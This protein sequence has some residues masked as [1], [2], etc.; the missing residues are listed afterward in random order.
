[1]R[2]LR[3]CARSPCADVQWDL[4]TLIRVV[5]FCCFPSDALMHTMLWRSQQW[6]EAAL[7]TQA[8]KTSPIKRFSK[9]MQLQYVC[10]RGCISEAALRK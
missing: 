4:V 5:G 3:T 1:M 10:E 2:S 9:D 7:Q 8:T 6:D